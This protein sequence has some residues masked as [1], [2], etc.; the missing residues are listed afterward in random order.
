MMRLVGGRAALAIILTSASQRRPAAA[1]DRAG[2]SAKCGLRS[3]G[4]YHAD[5]RSGVVLGSPHWVLTAMLLS[6]GT[7]VTL[8]YWSNWIPHAATLTFQAVFT[9]ALAPSRRAMV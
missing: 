3:C 1:P 4:R 5:A 7:L 9:C 8:P 6:L 2:R